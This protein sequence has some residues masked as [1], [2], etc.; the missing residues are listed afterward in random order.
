MF[1]SFVIDSSDAAM[2]PFNR[3]FEQYI[4]FKQVITDVISYENIFKIE[5][6]QA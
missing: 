4:N 3:E 2:V 6:R 5:R 1:I